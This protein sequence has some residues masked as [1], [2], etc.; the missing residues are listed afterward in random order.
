MMLLPLLLG[1]SAVE[2]PPH[3]VSRDG[4]KWGAP[5]KLR[6][7]ETCGV[8]RSNGGW[9]T[10]RK[11]LVAYI[12]VWPTGFRSKAGGYAPLPRCAEAEQ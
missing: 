3:A 1:P 7:P 11:T 12:N 8:M 9:W 5:C 10:G 4:L 2:T 6:G